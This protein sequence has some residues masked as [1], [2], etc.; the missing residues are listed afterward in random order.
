MPSTLQPLP[1]FVPHSVVEL[2]SHQEGDM[3]GGQGGLH[4][5]L[6]SLR[7]CWVELCMAASRD[8]TQQFSFSSLPKVF[9]STIPPSNL[10]EAS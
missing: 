10:P 6:G 4:D 9:Q 8:P 1:A 3:P 7:G 5:W 2:S